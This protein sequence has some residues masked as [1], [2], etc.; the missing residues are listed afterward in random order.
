MIQ[1]YLDVP[2]IVLG[3]FPLKIQSRNYWDKQHWAKKQQARQ[4]WEQLLWVDAVRQR[5]VGDLRTP[6]AKRVHFISLRTRLLDYDNLVGGFK[7]CQDAL[8]RMGFVV[9][10]TPTWL[11][12]LYTQQRSDAAP[13]TVIAIQRAPLEGAHA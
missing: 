7:Q 2:H 12:A 13:A 3:P 1:P 9:N 4:Q 11:R 6:F 8:Q 5:A 10:D